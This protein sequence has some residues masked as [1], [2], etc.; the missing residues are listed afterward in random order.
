M[1]PSYI[2]ETD[3]QFNRNEPQMQPR[4]QVS[5]RPEQR[6]LADKYTAENKAAVNNQNLIEL[7][8]SD[9]IMNPMGQMG[10]NM[11]NYPSR[12]V[13]IQNKL[14]YDAI[15]Q[16]YPYVSA[17]GMHNMYPYW[18]VPNNV[19]V[20]KNYNI[21]LPGPDGNH[22]KLSDLYED[23]LPNEKGRYLYSSTT[24]K[25]RLMLLDYMRSTFIRIGDGDDIEI[26]SK[27]RD[28][29]F[30]KNLLSYL[31]LLNL[32]PY[33]NNKVMPNPYSTLPN[34]MI[35]YRSCYPMRYNNATGNT[36]C[37]KFSIGLNLRIY[38]LSILE[39]NARGL[40]N[41]IFKKNHL[42]IWREVAYYEYIR[43]EILKKIICPN[44]VMMYSFFISSSTSID[45]KKLNKIKEGYTGTISTRKTDVIDM[46]NFKKFL[47]SYTSSG[48]ST[49]STSVPTLP[50]SGVVDPTFLKLHAF[51]NG[52]GINFEID[53]QYYRGGFIVQ[54]RSGPLYSVQFNEGHIEHNILPKY[55]R[56]MER[57]GRL[58]VGSKVKARDLK[59]SLQ[60]INE[61]TG[62]CLLVLTEAPNY[63]IIT[64]TQKIYKKDDLGPVNKMVQ[65]GFYTP[66]IW[67][68]VLAQILIAMHVMYIKEI[69]IVDMQLMDN[70]YIKDLMT[71]E[72]SVGYWKYVIDGI[73]YYIPNHGYMVK[74][75]T[76]FKDVKSND[77]SMF[78]GS[79]DN[80]STP[81]IYKTWGKLDTEYD[82][83]RDVNTKPGVTPVEYVLPNEPTKTYL[84][85]LDEI[86]YKNL[87]NIFNRNNFTK[88]FDSNYGFIP[89]EAK[90]YVG[91]L[92]TLINSKHGVDEDGNLENVI[93]RFLSNYVHN[94]T[95]LPLSNTEM[96]SV[97]VNLLLNIHN[98]KKGK[99][100]A[101][102]V[103]GNLYIWVMFIE[104]DRS[105]P[106]RVKVLTRMEPRETKE[107]IESF[108]LLS[109]LREYQ[110]LIE[111]EQK[112]KPQE[113]KLGEDELLET[114]RIYTSDRMSYVSTAPHTAPI[115]TPTPTPT[116]T[117]SSP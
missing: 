57:N 23:M 63:N 109:S 45:F 12:Y 72:Q 14:A 43:E 94:R 90:H 21:A 67:H 52:N 39:Y 38:D 24:L 116:P 27:I 74:I 54:I 9:K 66:E 44:F 101:H 111:I 108:V 70:I 95:G 11:V 26:N 50:I 6:S 104:E 29:V 115:S 53:N 100:Y 71:N 64:W 13:P 113:A 51:L 65:N 55:I 106:S 41:N 83:Y 49:L 110:S 17:T 8:L 32:N 20:V 28:D 30:S 19:P 31:K 68:S 69:S 60:N 78:R 1:L 93:P 40:S 46:N 3:N 34:R 80:L 92:Q 48:S 91:I 107:I 86:Q 98:L 35:M 2:G 77:Y 37:S 61:S 117:S 82:E 42:N 59:S 15:P 5:N 7:K 16:N 56:S 18:F 47:N 112:Y 75:D 103:R 87:Q 25:E 96:E 84:N 10:P 36:T 62:K 114:Y 99:L 105:N 22:T 73:N 76:N 85:K 97:D 4:P 89:D 79:L 81:E 33:H 58:T 88:E 102:N